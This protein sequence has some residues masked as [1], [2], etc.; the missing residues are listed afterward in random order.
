MGARLFLCSTRM[1]R[2]VRFARNR[3]LCDI[4]ESPLLGV[5]EALPLFLVVPN[6]RSNGILGQHCRTREFG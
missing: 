2:S 3:A 1:C 5:F 4:N 6:G